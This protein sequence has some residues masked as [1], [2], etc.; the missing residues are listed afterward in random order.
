MFKYRAG[1]GNRRSGLDTKLSKEGRAAQTI[2]STE[3][4]SVQRSSKLVLIE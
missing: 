1:S 3:G 2:L 4:S